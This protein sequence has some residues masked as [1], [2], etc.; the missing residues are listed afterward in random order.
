MDL[1]FI[2]SALGIIFISL[3]F[4]HSLSKSKPKSGAP[5]P[6]GR[7]G[8]PLLGESLDYF[9]KLRN[10]MNERFVMDRV[11]KYSSRV[12]KSNVLGE[13]MAFLPGAEGNKFLFS[14]ENKFVQVW[15]PSSVNSVFLKTDNRSA[16]DESIKV[17]RL[18]PPFLKAEALK[19]YVGIMDTV[20]KKHLDTHWVGSQVQ[21]CPLV[22][23]YTFTLACNLFLSLKDP[24]NLE[25]LNKIFDD[26]AC[27]IVSI[28]INLPGMSFY[29]AIK[30][31][32][33]IRGVIEGMVK[34]RKIDIA[35]NE[36][37]PTQDVMSHMIT[38]MAENK[39]EDPITDADI[40]SDLLGLLIGGYDTINTTLVFIMKFLAEQPHVYEEV[41]KEQT[42]IANLKQGK[43]LSWEDLRKMKYS[44]SVWCEVLRIR[45]PTVGA[46][47]VA[48]ADFAYGGYTIPK[49]WKLHYIPHVTHKNPEYFPNPDKFDPSRFEG[50]GPAPYTFVPFGGGPR[51]CPGAEYARAESLVFMHNVV[52]KFRWEKVIPDEKVATDPLPRP[53]NGLP[54]RLYTHN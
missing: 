39:S 36:A 14:N 17:R 28:P 25:K 22:R 16:Q 34:Q 37:T 49:G 38:A 10:G 7:S 6:P 46:F 4:H 26:V 42:E 45:P 53:I 40:A 43:L 8:W 2:L 11:Q 23:K 31:S 27:G 51:M 33:E 5:Y 47:R 1:L 24:E 41:L 21:V 44:W 9:S 35:E 19:A 18:L 30:A 29:K 50:S 20:C 54:I 12:F 3:F 52:T 32:Q 48:I 13:R 15:W